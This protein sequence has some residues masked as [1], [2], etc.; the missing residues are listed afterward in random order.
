MDG[1]FDSNITPNVGK[2]LQKIKRSAP[3]VPIFGANS[4]NYAHIL[5]ELPIFE[6]VVGEKIERSIQLNTVYKLHC[7]PH[8]LKTINL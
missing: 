4:L 5:F 1:S 8:P 3:T 6:E 2:K 7:S